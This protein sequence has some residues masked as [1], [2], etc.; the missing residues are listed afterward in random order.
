[1]TLH[2]KYRPKVLKDIIGQNHI[3]TSIPGVLK[4]GTS[5]AFLLHGPSGTGKTTIARI[6]A[7]ELGI[8]GKDM[9]EVDAA[10]YNGIDDMRNITSTLQYKPLKATQKRCIIIDEAQAITKGAWQSLLK[11]VEEPPPW[12]YWFLCTT[13]VEKI[14]TN[15]RN[16]CV[17]Y[18]T[19]RVSRKLLF[20]LLD[21]IAYAEK[22]DTTDGIIEL[23]A[24]EAN[25]SPRQAIVNLAACDGVKD[26]NE[27]NYI[28]RSA[29]ESSEAIE[30]ARALVARRGWDVV[31]GILRGLKDENA[32]TIRHSIRGYVT[33]IAL[34]EKSTEKQ[35]GNAL[36]I[37]DAFSTPFFSNDGISPVV[38]ACGRLILS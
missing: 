25:G 1:M 7:K 26:K 8:V 22:L 38:M 2:T 20:T 12:I 3:V 11:S 31:S 36:E 33:A 10:T 18:E 4:K 16:R 29:Q 9:L 15:I 14:P 5:H 28:L 17:A 6:A 21:D 13:E 27:A 34:G 24:R 35:V 32:E 37:L 23:C 30:L 19:K